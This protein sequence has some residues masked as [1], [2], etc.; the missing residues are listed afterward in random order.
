[1]QMGAAAH[2]NFRV[3]P[4]IKGLALIG[5]VYNGLVEDIFLRAGTIFKVKT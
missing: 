4:K 5:C 2:V 3:L 1:M